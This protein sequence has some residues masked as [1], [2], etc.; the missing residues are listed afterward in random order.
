MIQSEGT[1]QPCDLKSNINAVFR[2]QILQVFC[3]F[4]PFSFCGDTE[5]EALINLKCRLSPLCFCIFSETA[6]CMKQ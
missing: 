3:F 2:A 5:E 6:H 4:L 1:A